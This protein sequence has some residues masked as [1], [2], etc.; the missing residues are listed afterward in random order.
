MQRMSEGKLRAWLRIKT[1]AFANRTKL[2]RGKN[3]SFT[4]DELIGNLQAIVDE[5]K[6]RKMYPNF[7]S[8]E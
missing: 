7:P 8:K 4:V 6:L 5:A 1:E 3:H 2:M